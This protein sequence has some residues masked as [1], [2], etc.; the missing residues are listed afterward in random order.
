MP[1]TIN[2]DGIGVVDPVAALTYQLPPAPRLP[3]RDAGR[4]I[5]IPRQRDRDDGARNIVLAVT[6]VCAGLSLIALAVLAPK[7]IRRV[8]TDDAEPER[9]DSIA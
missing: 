8:Q 2:S 6:G 7:R 3:N 5:V 4:S 1:E 9:S